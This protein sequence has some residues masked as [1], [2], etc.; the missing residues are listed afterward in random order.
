MLFVGIF[1]MFLSKL[2]E[3]ML[4]L[5]VSSGDVFSPSHFPNVKLGH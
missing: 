5:T 2:I 1:L 4:I 3:F